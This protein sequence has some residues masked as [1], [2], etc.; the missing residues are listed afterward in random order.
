MN[1]LLQIDTLGDR[2]LIVTMITAASLTLVNLNHNALQLAA[3]RDRDSIRPLV[4]L[5]LLKGLGIDSR[6][7]RTT[8]VRLMLRLMLMI[9]GDHVDRADCS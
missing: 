3:G 9:F 4:H 1:F 8:L 6:P 2:L 5:L 7:L